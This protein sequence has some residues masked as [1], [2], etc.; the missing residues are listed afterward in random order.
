[1]KPTKARKLR[2]ILMIT[3]IVI[4]LL[5]YMS[6]IFWIVGAI[7][8]CSSLF[9]HFLFYKCPHCGRCLGRNESK[10]CQHCGKRIEES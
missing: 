4:M 8:A 10:F 1:M 6:E 3:G 2:D 5:G 7:V 9:M